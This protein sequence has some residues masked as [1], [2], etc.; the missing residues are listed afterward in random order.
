MAKLT[1]LILTFQKY[2]NEHGDMQ[3]V[4]RDKD[5]KIVDLL[6]C[7]LSYADN[8][9]DEKISVCWVSDQL[10]SVLEPKAAVDD[11]SIYV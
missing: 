2:F 4:F 5:N 11:D 6:S 8:I 3:V 10:T 9:K 7:G 1:D